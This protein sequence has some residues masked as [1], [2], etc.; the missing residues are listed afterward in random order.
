MSAV[1][2]IA[3]APQAFGGRPRRLAVATTG[4]DDVLVRVLTL[5]RRRRCRIVAVDFRDADAHGPGR[6]ELTVEVPPRANSTVERWLLAL[7]DVV[8]VSSR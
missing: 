4:R 8:A 5:L 3:P 7:V 6:F 2:S 1:T